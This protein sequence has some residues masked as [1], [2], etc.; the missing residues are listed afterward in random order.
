[1]K[2]DW[3]RHILVYFDRLRRKE[4]MVLALFNL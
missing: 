4:M 2:S 3:L 1:M